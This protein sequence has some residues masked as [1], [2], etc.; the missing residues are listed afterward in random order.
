[1]TTSKMR[2][3]GAGVWVIMLITFLLSGCGQDNKK[4]KFTIG[5]SQC[6]GSDLW[7]RTM[8]EEMKMEL[9]LHP[10]ANFIYEDAGGNSAQQIQQVRR[11]L[12]KGIDLLIISPNEARPLTPI[13]EEVY[14]RGIPV[15]IIDRKTASP[16]YTSYVGADNYQVGKI[17]GQYISSQATTPVNLIEVMGLPGSSPAIER[18]RGLTEAIRDNKNVRLKAKVYG[19]WLKEHAE[20]QLWKIREQL[21]DA[22]YIFAQNDV[23]AAGARNILNKLNLSGSV[24][25]IGV[26]ALPGTG[27]G[28][29]M[30]SGKMLNASLLYPTG[31]KE[32]IVTAFRILSKEPFSRENNMQSLVIDSSNVQL[33]KMQWNKINSQ[34][35]DIEKQQALLEEQRAVYNSQQVVLNILVITLVLTI[36]LGGL[37]SFSLMENRKINKSLEAKNMEILA[38]RNQLVEMS[39]KAKV[40]AEA[41]LNFFTNISHEFRTPLTL[42]L[43]VVDDL[44]KQDRM[45]EGGKNIQIIRKNAFRLLK[46][47]NQLLDYRKIEYDKQKIKASENDLVAYVREIT[48]SFRHHAQK[49]NVQLNCISQDREMKVWFDTQMLDK[50]F[51][52]LISNALKFTRDKGLVYVRIWQDGEGYA[53]VAVED[54]GIG[55]SP[56]ETGQLFNQFYQADHTP[57]V[58][59]GI[60]LSLSRE[61][62]RLHQGMIEVKSEK[63]NGSVFTVR[64]PLGSGHLSQEEKVTAQEDMVDLDRQS[65]LYTADF[66]LVPAV[67]KSDALAAPKEF[68]VLLVEDNEDLLQYL[69]EKLSEH[70]EVYTAGNGPAALNLAFQWVPDLILSDVVIPDLSGKSLCGKLKSDFRTSHIPVVLLTAQNSIEQQISGMN[71]MADLYITKPFNFDFLLASIQNLIR[72]RIK[73]KEHFTSDIS[74]T[75]KLALPKSLDRKFINDFNGIIEQN[76]SN[77]KFSVDDICKEIG[78]S[79]VQLYRKVKALLGYSVSDYILNRR[80]KKAEYLLANEDY[81]IAEVTYMIGFANPNYFST[82]FKSKYGCTPTE[83]KKQRQL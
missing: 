43:S 49:L 61:I 35:K 69:E 60:G 32:A 50:V 39:E 73:L 58:G 44:L 7:R 17:A 22:S 16:L 67:K 54:N 52:N 23:M 28:L 14:N 51:F 36:V 40:A 3:Y 26:D 68:S 20:K 2:L 21:K 5:F 47:V 24:K 53:C 38:Q 4:A 6:V 72:N 46:L 45:P 76:L 37:A 66:D 83:F 62:V 13:V 9:S 10:G 71:A 74:G 34:Q 33:M 59:S 30:V 56:G 80:M 65:K 75:E 31:G 1:M 8:L 42:M 78:V 12:D 57:T 18:D 25:V 29:E 41:K 11:L 77:D 63:W 79:R 48:E 70:Y 19:N 82:A 81:T 64:L 15:I 55:M 27:G